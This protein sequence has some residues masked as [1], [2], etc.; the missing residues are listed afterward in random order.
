MG[1][2]AVAARVDFPLLGLPTIPIF[3]LSV[4]DRSSDLTPVI[5]ANGFVV[6][7]WFLSLVALLPQLAVLVGQHFVRKRFMQRIPSDLLLFGFQAGDALDE[8]AHNFRRW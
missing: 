8:F 2:R 5:P 7:C 3:N 4:H 6:I 1:V